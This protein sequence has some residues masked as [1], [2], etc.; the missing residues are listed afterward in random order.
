MSL[1]QNLMGNAT[2]ILSDAAQNEFQPILVE[3]ET[4]TKAFKLIRDQI[5]MTN[6]R[7]ISINKQGVTGKKQEMTS[8]PY[9]SI[10]KFSKESAGHFDLDAEL[11]I[12]LAGETEPCKWDFSRGVDIN[13]VYQVLSHYVLLAKA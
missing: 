5:V 11:R 4:V 7:L 9:S 12:W 1:L 10:K 3:G 8:I 2:E 6:L 13:Q